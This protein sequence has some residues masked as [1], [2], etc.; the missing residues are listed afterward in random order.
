MFKHSL[1]RLQQ[2]RY[3]RFPDDVKL[4]AVPQCNTDPCL[5]PSYVGQQISVAEYKPNNQIICRLNVQIGFFFKIN[6]RVKGSK[7][8]HVCKNLKS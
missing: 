7:V 4:R 2:G 5:D 8:R 1:R 3:S 6:V